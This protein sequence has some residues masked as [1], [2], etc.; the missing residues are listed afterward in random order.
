M[1]DKLLLLSGNEIPFI[2]AQITIHQ[3]TLKEIAFIGEESFFTGCEY[4]NFS[5]QKLKEQDKNHLSAFNSFEI[6]MTMM[7]ENNT[8]INK[9]KTCMELVLLLLFPQYKIDFLPMSIMISKLNDKNE[10]EIH[11][12]DKD[13]FEIFQNIIKQIFCFKEVMKDDIS[14]KYNPAGP[15]AKALVQKFK[16]RQRKI[17]EIK[18]QNKKSSISIFSRYISILAVGEKKDINKLL[19]YTVYQLFDE[20][21]RFRM[22]QDFDLYVQ[23]KMAGAKDL[24]EIENWMDEIHP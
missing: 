3:P 6:L 19:Q 15:Q 12:I 14:E 13:N 2:Q 21:Y 23:A 17:A 18:N 20:F 16:Q 24:E 7:R 9:Y 5:K 1:I 22:K 4:L 10:K 8:S 11:L